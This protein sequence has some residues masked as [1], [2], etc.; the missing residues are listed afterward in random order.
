MARQLA[1]EAVLV[2]RARHNAQ[3]LNNSEPGWYVS[4]A[5]ARRALVAMPLWD[6]GQPVILTDPDPRALW[7][8]MRHVEQ[9]CARHRAQPASWPA[10][11]S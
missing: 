9:E 8:Q 5:V 2:D 10:A 6:P 7:F 4:F 1:D 3:R 11:P